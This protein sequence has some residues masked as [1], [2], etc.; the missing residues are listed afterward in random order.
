MPGSQHKR[1]SLAMAVTN[2]LVTDQ[3][4]HR[5]AST[6]SEN[7]IN[8]TLIGRWTRNLPENRIPFRIVRLNP[9]VQK[10]FLFYA[11]FNLRLFFHLLFCRYDAV[12]AND[13]DTLTACFLAC[14][15][16]RIPVLYDSHEYF[17][18]LPELINRPFVRKVWL[19]LEQ[20]ML[21][22]IRF[23]STVS[24]PIAEIYWQ[25][26]G[27]RA[28]IVR[29]V[30]VYRPSTPK[31]K[32][33][34]PGTIIYQGSI[35]MGRGIENV[36]KAL[37][38]LPEVVF[39]IA[40]EGY[41]LRSLQQLVKEEGVMHRVTFTGRLLPEILYQYTIRADVGI[42]LEERIGDNYYY[43]LPNKLFDY[44]QARIPVLVSA[45]PAMK[46][47]V[48]SYKIGYTTESQDPEHLASLLREM[49]FND[50]L[51][52]EW[53]VNLERAAQE[54]CWENEKE[55]LLQIYRS[56]GLL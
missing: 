43:A 35:N 18:A 24:Y 53:Q 42:S 20:M 13:L 19:F 2:D 14:R 54:L 9:L 5:I 50:L 28:E 29:N 30:P 22:H 46:E 44:I 37:H 40:G 34:R 48:D 1:I 38:Y 11:F 55:K 36:I 39:I 26:Y 21:P 33:D 41:L 8:V 27:V 47:I 25:L 51:R 32:N 23:V 7:G 10:G 49:L 12:T 6:L 56:A 52:K 45:F 17:T 16:K 15:L 4:L 3:R 31:P